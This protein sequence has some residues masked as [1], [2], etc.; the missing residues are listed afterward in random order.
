MTA[1]FLLATLVCSSSPISCFS[2]CYLQS[3]THMPKAEISESSLNLL[4]NQVSKSLLDFLSQTCFLLHKLTAL[5]IAKILALTWMTEQALYG[6]P[7]QGLVCW[8]G[9]Q[10]L[11]SQKSVFPI[12][13][14]Q[15]FTER[16]RYRHD[17][18]LNF[19]FINHWEL[20]QL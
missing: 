8:C 11:G 12:L 20:F 5:A 19:S 18:I 7:S 15:F 4:P 16:I 1:C 3:F 9:I 17:H 13:V 14:F 6:F 2:H 10:A